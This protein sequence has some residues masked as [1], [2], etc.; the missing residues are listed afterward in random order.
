MQSSAWIQLLRQ[1]PAENHDKIVLMTSNGTD[2]NL[3]AVLRLEKDYVALRGRLAASTE[4]GRVFF[5]PYDQLCL[6]GFRE[7]VPEAKIMQ[8]F[9]S[10]VPGAA[11]AVAPEALPAA[12]EGPLPEGDGNGSSPAPVSESAKSS[13][14]SL[15]P[16]KA[17][18]LERLRRARGPDSP[19]PPSS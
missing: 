15:A 6:I 13:R 7:G 14:T 1:I 11:A 18:L 5:V 9:G 10:A 12:G 4:A 17:A 2:I 16:A 8:M 19:K 3:Q